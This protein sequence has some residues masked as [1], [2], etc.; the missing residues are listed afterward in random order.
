LI[1]V[2]ATISFFVDLSAF[3]SLTDFSGK[4]VQTTEQR[5]WFL[6]FGAV[7]AFIGIGFLMLRRWGYLKDPI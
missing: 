1:V 5:I 2:C 3:V 4:P 7:L 6:A